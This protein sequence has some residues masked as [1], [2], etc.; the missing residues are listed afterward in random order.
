MTC[1]SELSRI[2]FLERS[3]ILYISTWN[4]RT[5]F[6]SNEQLWLN[7]NISC[8]HSSIFQGIKMN[9]ISCNQL[10]FYTLKECF[11]NGLF[12]CHQVLGKCTKSQPL[13]SESNG[14][15]L[16]SCQKS[17]SNIPYTVSTPASQG[18][19]HRDG[20]LWCS[21][22][23]SPHDP[24]YDVHLLSIPNSFKAC[25]KFRAFIS[26][27]TSMRRTLNIPPWPICFWYCNVV[28]RLL[29]EWEL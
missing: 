1:A 17:V 21:V 3:L 8:Y 26:A 29:T 10:I 5:K 23:P 16:S 20:P 25:S 28:Q 6:F 12:P 27:S 22:L 15:T 24:C 7:D 13:T 9:L 11:R 14:H 4:P 19:F 2:C 18:L